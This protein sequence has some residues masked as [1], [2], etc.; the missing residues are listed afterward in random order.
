MKISKNTL[1]LSKKLSDFFHQERNC[2]KDGNEKNFV[3]D[4]KEVSSA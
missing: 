3:K 4:L 2:V 1:L